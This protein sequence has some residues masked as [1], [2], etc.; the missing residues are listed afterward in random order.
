MALQLSRAD[1]AR[2]QTRAKSLE[3]RMKKVKEKS[4]SAIKTAVRTFEVTGAAFVG[5]ALQ[6]YTY[7]PAKG[8]AGVEVMGVPLDLGLGVA[9][10][11]LGFT[12]LG[13]GTAEHAHAMS[14]GL[15]AC[16]AATYGRSAGVKLKKQ[17]DK[18]GA[19]KGLIDG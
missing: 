19:T 10:H 1:I 7:D 8:T 2:L 17:M 11:M 18:G 13:E 5:G 15:L 14:D 6:G 4:E 12:V 9:G 16:A 3:G